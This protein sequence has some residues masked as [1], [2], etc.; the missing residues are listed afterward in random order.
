[1]M[2]ILMDFRTNPVRKTKEE[3]EEEDKSSKKLKK[4]NSQLKPMD[5]SKKI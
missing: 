1:M 5:N 4:K 3:E 2:I